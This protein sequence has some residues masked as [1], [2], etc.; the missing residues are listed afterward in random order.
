V[1]SGGADVAGEAQLASKKNPINKGKSALVFIL[2][3]SFDYYI[4][5]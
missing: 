5:R 3:S 2:I 1:D 4:S